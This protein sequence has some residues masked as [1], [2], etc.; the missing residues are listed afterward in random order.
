M[1]RLKS[2]DKYLATRLS[3]KEIAEI[4]KQA[5]LEKKIFDTLQQDVAKAMSEFMKKNDMGFNDIVKQLDCS[6]TH[7]AKI[8][9]G[10]ANL[11]LSS[12]AHLFAVLGE[13]PH[14]VLK[15]K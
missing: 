2:F 10:T 13:E 3:K 4:D 7:V 8:Q 14:L 11:T 5:R 1:V 9:K 15:K 12:L 6:P